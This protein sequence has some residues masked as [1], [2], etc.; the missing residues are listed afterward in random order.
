MW[1]EFTLSVG[2]SLRRSIDRG[3]AN[4]KFGIVIISPN[5]LRKNWPQKELDGPVARELGGVKVLLP[6]CHEIDADKIRAY[7][8]TLADRVAVST[9]KGLDYVTAELI[10]A[11]WP[12]ESAAR[13]TLRT[14]R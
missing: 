14:I 12:E 5:F 8:P 2:E 13:R 7:S 9:V 4:S 1:F 3:S 6:V 11:I 10:R